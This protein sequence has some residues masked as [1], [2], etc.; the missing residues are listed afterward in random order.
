MRPY[1]AAVAGIPLAFS[2]DDAG[3]FSLT[4]STAAAGGGHF[5][6]GVATAVVLP[7]AV[8]PNGYRAVTVGGQVVSVPGA[9]VLCLVAE[10][11]AGQVQLR[12]EPAAPGTATPVTPANSV[13]TCAAPPGANTPARPAASRPAAGTAAGA[14]AGS[15]GDQGG[16]GDDLALLVLFPLLGAVGMALLLGAAFRLLHRGRRPVRPPRNADVPSP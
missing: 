2:A 9:S 12:V 3:G 14:V 8:Y 13:T 1:P 11:G 6:G 5:D 16:R 10:P 15:P 4:Y 7:A